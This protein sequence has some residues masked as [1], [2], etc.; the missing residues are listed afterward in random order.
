MNSL[1]RLLVRGIDRRDFLRLCG[2]TAAIF[3]LP[4][5]GTEKI[6]EAAEKAMK[7]PAVI[8][9]QGQDC[10][11]CTESLLATL[12]PSIESLLLD[13]I[14]LRYHE[15][16]MGA[17]GIVA[18]E[19]LHATQKEG[20]YIL[21]VEGSLPLA[22]DEFCMVGG[23]PWTKTVEETA[24]NAKAVVAVGACATYGGIPAAGP[25]GA[26]GVS[27]VVKDKPVINLPMC[28]AKPSQVIATLLYVLSHGLENF[29]LDEHLRPK[30]FYSNLI[31]DNCPRR[32]RFENGEFLNDWNDPNQ[33][34]WCLLLKGCKGPKTYTDCAQV[35][36]NDGANFCINAGSPCSGC[37]QPEFYKDFATLYAKTD[38][39]DMPGF[40]QVSAATVGKVIGGAAAV[41]VGVHF[42]AGLAKGST[43]QE[44]KAKGVKQNG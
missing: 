17:T 36:W 20:D 29:E 39:F 4:L 23:V 12:N 5:G 30:V 8:W 19:A 40:G 38:M 35:W 10:A 34:D 33:K 25:T 28:P 14:S 11:G 7:K 42:A 15:T 21:V 41:G 43:K 9:L 6:V 22:G 32:G 16:I 44:E 37:A 18:E 24:K 3:S 26:A 2:T 31:H 27:A 1:E 13:T